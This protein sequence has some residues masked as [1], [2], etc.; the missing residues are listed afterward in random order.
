MADEFRKLVHRYYGPGG[1][2][3]PCC[4]ERGRNGKKG[5]QIANRKARAKLKR[6]VIDSDYISCYTKRSG[7]EKVTE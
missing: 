6:K 2:N 7:D 3:C 4:G 1:P 5:K